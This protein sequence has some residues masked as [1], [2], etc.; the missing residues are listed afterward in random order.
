[1]QNSMLSVEHVKH[2]S[3]DGFLHVES[4]LPLDLTAN[5]QEEI[6]ALFDAP[7]KE[8]V[9][10]NEPMVVC[11]R[12]RPDGNRSIF[13]LSAAPHIASILAR[14]RLIDICAKLARANFLQL[15]E[16]V[17]FNKPAGLGEAFA[18]HNDASFYP[19]DPANHVSA[20]IAIDESAEE[21][22]A[23]HF[24]RGS[25]RI[26]N[27]GPVN[28]KTGESLLQGVMPNPVLSH[29]VAK[30]FEVKRVDMRPGDAVIFDGYTLH[31][32]PPNRSQTSD[33][34]GMSFRFLTNPA[35]FAPG[36][37]KSAPFVR[38]ISERPGEV[39]SNPCF[40]VLYREEPTV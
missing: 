32:S 24:L 16:V 8:T 36:K 17:I 39:V 9:P 15:F 14:T 25:Q 30:G 29:P 1:M 31:C 11:W 5:V 27:V 2:Y 33:R 18:W 20:W 21:T 38:Q 19:F 34:R 37:G 12:H 23:L 10:I 13:P 26:K 35:K 3:E 28:I 4:V 7:V 40:P 6:T 22:G